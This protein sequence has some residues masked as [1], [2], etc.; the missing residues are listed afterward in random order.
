[1]T[2]NTII[3]QNHTPMMVQYLEIKHAHSDCMLFY[4]MGDFYELFYDDAV[5][6]A[7]ALDI[8]LTKRGQSNGEPI[9]MAGV[10][11]NSHELYLLKLIEKGFRV[12]VCEQIETPEQAKAR[13]TKGPL[14]RGVVRIITPGTLTEESLLT[15]KKANYLVVVSPI[16]KK[17]KNIGIAWADIST[18][19]FF[20][21][22]I[23]ADHLSS[24]LYQ[25][26][27]SEILMPESVWQSLD[28]ELFAQFKKIIR[29]LSDVRYNLNN[30]QKQLLETFKALT[31]EVFGLTKPELI[32][33]SGVLCDYLKLTQQTNQQ[34]LRSPKFIESDLFIK[35]DAQSC[36]N[37]EIIRTL[38]SNFEGSLL[39]TIDNTKTGG[40]GRL[41]FTNITNPLKNLQLLEQRFKRIDLFYQQNDIRK[42]VRAALEHCPDL[43]RSLTRISLN[44]GL[45]RD[46]KAI[47]QG[48]QLTQE[49]KTLLG[50][51]PF[52]NINCP[53]E[54]AD[55]LTQNL[56]EHMPVTHIDGG[57][58]KQG[59]DP[60]LDDLRHTR[61]FG[62]DQIK[63]LEQLYQQQSGI[64]NLKIRTNNLIGYFI[65]V[66]AS[67]LSKVPEHFFHRQAI[68]NG[69]RYM[70]TQ[71]QE[72]A[73]KLENA[74]TAATL[75]EIEL[76]TKLCNQILEQREALETIASQLAEIDFYSSMAE[77]AKLKGYT[78]PLL[79]E[80]TQLN[81]EGGRH[82][83]I[84]T[85][86][87]QEKFT[88]NNCQLNNPKFALLTGPNMAGKST[89]LR[90]NA[91]II[92]MAHCGIYVPAT[93]AEIGLVDQIFSRIGAADDLAAGRSTFM[94]EMV[95]TASILHQASE[96][97]FIILDEIGRG[98]S[99]QDGLA[100]ARAVSEHI[101]TNIKARCLFA[102]HYHEL[103]DLEK[104]YL[105]ALL[106]MKI[107][108]HDNNVVFLHE[109]IDGAADKSYGIH[110]AEL[111]G[112]PQTV[113]SRAQELLETEHVNEPKVFAVAT[114]AGQPMPGPVNENNV[115][116]LLRSIKPD[117]LSPKQALEVIY[118]LKNLQTDK[119]KHK[120]ELVQTK[121]F[122]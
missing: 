83:I 95:E 106:T 76:F 13:G 21:Q 10:P 70:T 101:I 119:E 74:A 87:G 34:S 11:V 64:S 58:I 18:G 121:L 93:K 116:K 99:T 41:L 68:S 51:Q 16:V 112:L 36:R 38:K 48:L 47:C 100:I 122:S 9:P 14:K 105:V 24:F 52:W 114:L 15:P 75:Y 37:L 1:M 110:V 8:S 109:V 27:A 61:D 5:Q 59:A 22:S 35:V 49:I 62:K 7:A 40:G 54:L 12:A 72:L 84:E 73:T 104:N 89:Y 85:Y 98:T 32:Q 33:A 111:A 56:E 66:S 6:A 19:V 60:V 46:L 80:D 120:L 81:I 82:P 50:D 3:S 79:S 92:W 86:V 65:E 78:K 103:S 42:L 45:P 28:S 118:K 39:H 96:R 43:E 20:V 57:I 108:E 91:L 17:I 23:D 115:L 53:T 88:K 77:L 2:S 63:E 117:D 67:H 90:Q 71:L 102:T 4:R 69:A 44:R 113:I 29:P 94:V 97:S 30:A 55:K 31:P 25:L 107:I 26:D